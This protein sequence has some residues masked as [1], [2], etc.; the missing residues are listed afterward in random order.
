MS[1]F[2]ELFAE[3]KQEQSPTLPAKKSVSQKAKPKPAQ[4]PSETK[5]TSARARGRRSDPNYT[6]AFAY[7]PTQLHEDVRRELFGRKDLDFSGLV[8]RL[9]TDWLKKQK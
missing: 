6:G 4:S 7:I 1:K 9:L 2:K 8:E 5:Q 3:A